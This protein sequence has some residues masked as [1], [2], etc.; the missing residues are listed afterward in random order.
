[1][2]RPTLRLALTIALGLSVSVYGWAQL[3]SVSVTDGYNAAVVNPAALAVGNAA[4]VAGELGYTSG[5]GDREQEIGESWALFLSGNRLG[6]AYQQSP[7]FDLH[8]LSSGLPL[9]EDLYGGL[10][11]RWEPGGFDS[12]EVRLGALYRP[13][14]ALSAG[15]TVTVIED[16]RAAAL[17][18]LA[19]RP[20]ALLTGGS[21]RLTISGDLPYDGSAWLAPRV[22]IGAVPVEG[23]EL[24][25]GYDLELDRFRGALSLSFSALRLGNRSRLEADNDL[26]SGALF[27]H[28][29]PKRFRS[30]PSIGEQTFIDY[31]PG[32]QVVERR[33]LPEGWP[34]EQLDPS[35]SVLEVASEIRRMARDEEVAGI[36]F[37]KHLFS[38]STSN[39]LEIISAL[40]EF[41]G[42]GKRVVYYYERVDNLNYALAAATGDA[43]YLH[44]AGSVALTGESITR[45]YLR[46]LLETLGVEVGNYTSGEF[47]NAGNIYSDSRMGEAERES[48]SFLLDGL[49]AEF[50]TLIEEGRGDRLRRPVAETVD[51]GPYLVAERA[52]EAGLVDRLLYEDELGE[53]LE[54]FGEA[55]AIR[56][57]DERREIRYAWRE[58]LG[59]RVALI[60][61]AGPITLGAGQPG[62]VAAA[63]TVARAIREARED[64]SVEAILLRVATGGGSA[65][66]SETIAREVRLTREAEEPKPVIISMGDVAASG[67]YYLSAY[68]DEILAYPTTVTGSI[69]VVT[70]R[71]NIDALS[72]NLG[73][74]WETIRRGERSDFGAPY[75]RPTEAES[76]LLQES[77]DEAYSRFLSVVAEGRGMSEEEVDAVGRGRVWTGGQAQERGL[78]DTL[79]GFYDAIDSIEERLGRQVYLVEYTGGDGVFGAPIP[80][81]E[82]SRRAL[83]G[84]STEPLPP[85]VRELYRAAEL[86]R[87]FEG[88]RLLY[89]APW[90][91]R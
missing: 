67:G 54:A 16:D 91:S 24:Q 80:L 45:P 59:A 66:A 1:M 2:Q 60:Y 57:R 89:L 14:D 81:R 44:P 12:G 63:D 62:S 85:P 73:I 7:A 34:F 32:P 36:L 90:H 74:N 61:V 18:G 55:P 27:A 79:G 88:E 26:D 47:K 3:A 9:F 17:V 51:G 31:A 64:R 39:T 82:L 42:A 56:Y 52:L 35:V 70:L 21:H 41:R 40:E 72:D 10:A 5:H 43:I 77:V 29:S 46:E 84:E 87:R 86:L 76:R 11:Y 50:L 30:L 23:L 25:I 58:N 6:Y 33:S 75:R 78:V 71:P 69:G 20:L 13:S 83:L 53:A 22:A 8:T 28:L 15:A 19:L 37:R 49:Y 65:L 38:A 68:A 48:L 4:G